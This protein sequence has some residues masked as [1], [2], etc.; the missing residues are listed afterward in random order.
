MQILSQTHA[1]SRSSAG[2]DSALLK[3][4]NNLAIKNSELLKADYIKTKS[5]N[6]FA[7]SYLKDT[8]ETIVY[9]DSVTMLTDSIY[10]KIKELVKRKWQSKSTQ[11][12]CIMYVSVLKGDKIPNG[13]TDAFAFEF[14]DKKL[15]KTIVLNYPVIYYQ[16]KLFFGKAIIKTKDKNFK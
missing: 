10:A 9:Q 5:F 4:L 13:S 12:T 14:D 11:R 7:I 16:N 1:Q 2:I 3:E 15:E 6:P 8:I